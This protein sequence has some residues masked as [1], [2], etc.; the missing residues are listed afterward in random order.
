M[1]ILFDSNVIIDAITQ[2][3]KS[4]AG[5]K[6]LYLKAV[7]KEIRGYLVS[8]QITDIAYVLRK[9]VAKDKIRSFCLFL[10]RAFIILPF[11][12][13]DIQEAALLEGKDFEDDILIYLAGCNSI[14]FIATNNTADYSESSVMALRPEEILTKLK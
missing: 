10:C 2:R 9:Y 14:D 5:A 1:N 7:G 11:T 6:D 4:N 8:K 13:D 3:D 12:K